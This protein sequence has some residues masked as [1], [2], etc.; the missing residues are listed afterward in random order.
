MGI[1]GETKSTGR[2]RGQRKAF[3]RKWGEPSIKD[4]EGYT[5]RK[6]GA[7]VGVVHGKTKNNSKETEAAGNGMEWNGAE[8]EFLSLSTGRLPHLDRFCYL[9]LEKNLVGQ[10]RERGASLLLIN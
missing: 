2:Q 3:I 1:M 9:H 7:I 6:G 4:R 10:R 5:R 8:K